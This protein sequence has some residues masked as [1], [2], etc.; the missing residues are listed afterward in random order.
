MISAL[1]CA[2]LQCLSQ[3][4]LRVMHITQVWETSNDKVFLLETALMSIHTR[5]TDRARMVNKMYKKY[6][7]MM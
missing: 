6:V 4:L 3:R 2:L 1:F 5:N 7:P